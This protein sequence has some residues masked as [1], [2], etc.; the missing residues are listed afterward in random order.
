[1]SEFTLIIHGWSDC[2][3]SFVALKKQLQKNG[4]GD[5]DTILYGDYQSRED[6]ITFNDVVDGLNDQMKEK[7]LIEPDGKKVADLNIVVHSTGGLV[8]RHWIWHYYSHRM[9]ECPVKRILMLA[10]ANFGSPLA[11]RGKSFLGRLVKGRWKVGD[12]LEVGRKLLDGLELASPYQWQLA[13]HDI[14]NGNSSYY[15]RDQ[16]QLTILTGIEDYSGLRGWVNKPGTD[17]T[18]VISGAPLNS[19]KLKLN[20]SNVDMP[21]EWKEMKT[22]DDFCFG[23]LPDLDH[24]SIVSS[25]EDDNAQI[26]KIAVNAL[27]I[28]SAEEFGEFKIQLKQK[29]DETYQNYSTKDAKRFSKYQQFLIHGLDDH[30]EPVRDFTFEFEVYKTEKASEQTVSNQSYFNNLEKHYSDQFQKLLLSQIHTHIKDASYRRLLVNLHEMDLL[31]E[32][33]RDQLGEFVL[34]MKIYIPEIDKGI[35]YD[36]DSLQNIVIYRS[37]EK[38]SAQKVPSLFYENTTTLLEFSVDRKT[39]YVRIGEEPA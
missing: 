23:V 1:M 15:N 17:G 31:M 18:I 36:V 37:D 21:Y 22:A 11:H 16:I 7:G 25:F 6:N 39:K 14:F 33:T 35:F 12:L 26:I 13:H 10:P 30:G 28:N 32:E 24:G 2:S 3:S 4:I 20:F 38:E 9:E 34:I 27:K 19:V 8:I 5:V 29:T